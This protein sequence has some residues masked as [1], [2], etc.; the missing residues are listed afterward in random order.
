MAKIS[1]RD[2]TSDESEEIIEMPPV[3]I[4][5]IK[6]PLLSTSTLSMTLEADIVYEEINHYKLAPTDTKSVGTI[7][8]I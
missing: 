5:S 8:R 2:D 1:K 4:Q 7:V 6:P 3:P